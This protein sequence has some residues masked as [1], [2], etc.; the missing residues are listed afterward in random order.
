[1]ADLGLSQ[2]A[3]REVALGGKAARRRWSMAAWTLKGLLWSAALLLLALLAWRWPSQEGGLILPA[4]LLVAGQSLGDFNGTLFS[5]L[6]RLDLDFKA[7]I[8]SK[9]AQ[10]LAAAL[11]LLAH[12]SVGSVLLAMALAAWAGWLWGFYLLKKQL[13]GRGPLP[14]KEQA[15]RLGRQLWPFGLF[16]LLTLAYVKVDTLLLEH[17]RGLET[18]GEYQ[19]AYL[20]FERLGFLPAAFVAASFPALARAGRQGAS[21]LQRRLKALRALGGT[22]VLV[23]GFLAGGAYWLPL[24]WL[25]GPRY[26][27]APLLLGALAFACL[28]YFPNYVL[29]SLLVAERQQQRLVYGALAGLLFNVGGNLWA[30]P[31]WGALGAAWMTSA[32]EGLILL[33]AALSLHKTLALRHWI[34]SALLWILG[35][36]LAANLGRWAGP[37]GFL[38]GP[39]GGAAWAWGLGLLPRD[40]WKRWRREA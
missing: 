32:T 16:P 15:L 23:T 9:L 38:L 21:G 20:W 27:E 2:L 5:A 29:F 10:V 13:P 39:L 40:E 11:A 22:A 4:G 28:A 26:A 35:G 1:L 31:R 3:Q 37:W 18:V 12:A 17:L 19:A 6:E 25:L 36:I 7:G 24:P 14:L 34:P 30:I 33:A 8:L